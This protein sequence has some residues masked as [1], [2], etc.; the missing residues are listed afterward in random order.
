MS[1][2]GRSCV[3]VTLLVLAACSA[4]ES[5][6][7]RFESQAL[8]V[9]EGRCTAPVCH[10][11]TVD[12][13]ERGEV[14]DHT[15]LFVA[16]NERGRILDADE[17]YSVTLRAVDPTADPALSSLL[18]KPLPV[19]YGGSPHH[20]GDGF[21]SPLD[22]GF[23]ALA[24]WI[25]SEETGG[26]SEHPLNPLEQ[27][28]A[29]D[30]LPAL[31]SASCL[32]GNCHGLDAAV[33]FRLDPGVGGARSPAVI[34]H[35]YDAVRSMLSPGADP[36]RARIIR[37]SLPLHAGGIVHK[38]GN[39]GFFDA[40]SD[41]R[42]QAIADWACAERKQRLGV[43]CFDPTAPPIEGLVFVRGP[44]R[45]D[46][47]FDADV[48]LPGSDLF[49]AEVT[50]G[51]LAAAAPRN[52]TAG[53]HA[54][55]ADVRDPAVSDDGERVAFAMRTAADGGH[56]LWELELA[57]G[58]ARQLTEDAGPMDGGAVRTHRDPTYG[59]TGL[60][61]FVSTRAGV[62]GDRGRLDTDLYSLDPETG[63]VVRRT[64][65]PHLE[66][67]PVFLVTGEESGGE[68]GFTA[69]RDVLPAQ[70]RAHPFRFPP[71]LTTEY[72]QHF[73]ITP[74]ENLFDD[75]RE[76]PD[77][78]FVAVIGDLDAPALTGRLGLIDRNFG[79]E[80]PGALG[81]VP[82]GLPGYSAPLIRLEGAYRDPAPLPDGRILASWDGGG[83]GADP[84]DED[85]PAPDMRIVALTL[86]DSADGA[87]PAIVAR[88]L[89]IDEPGTHDYDP[90]PVHVRAPAPVHGPDKWDPDEPTG[91]FVHN[92]M[93]VID[94]LL[95]AL[96]PTGTK[97]P[98]DQFVAVRLV[99]ALPQTPDDANRL[100]VPGDPA[101]LHPARV[102]AELPLAKDGTFQ[103]EVPAGVPFRLQGLDAAGL[104][105]GVMHNRWYFVAPG[106]KVTQGVAEGGYGQRC[107]VCHGAADGQADHTFRAPDVLTMASVTLSRYEGGDPRRPM[108]PQIVGDS[109]RMSVGFEE[110][111]R[112]LLATCATT[113]CHGA[114][115][116][117][118]DIDLATDPWGAL[119]E[120]ELLDLQRGQ[121]RTSLL[122]QA[123]TDGPH[124][125]G[126]SDE[127]VRAVGRWIDLGAPWRRP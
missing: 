108:D 21:T 123:V 57:S 100:V 64:W 2:T 25:A 14:I 106:Q 29:D 77:G 59:P 55:P 51:S 96:P 115:D 22:P 105:I 127:W 63:A 125:I 101:L 113:G 92:G 34:R 43:G 66:R 71:E 73:G 39:D 76:L 98:V 111:I 7:E 56:D 33:P 104:T 121:A 116:P 12:A 62:L 80:I 102:L 89:V 11:Y 38:G 26:E 99:E 30:V 10:G 119:F 1:G 122:I 35:N 32:N 67:K 120:H 28:F 82:T 90:E 49:F 69:L 19:T 31:E 18:R 37:K 81:D 42:V 44:L 61:W 17:A 79:P 74:P 8:P 86:R 24:E 93:P 45:A 23:I 117:A 126:A 75:M 46:D 95:A 15:R 91:L 65:T 94:A 68:I 27:Q 85:E 40:L 20:G 4:Q 97:A 6:R 36:W 103:V 53:L 107:A 9:L 114:D 58:Q 118:G 47:P 88:D 109:T 112:P 70:R 78:R 124:P 72:H 16:V 87:G 3:S 110:D 52:L 54:A 41:P 60:I 84:D 13:P 83:I 50:D 5:P 48:F